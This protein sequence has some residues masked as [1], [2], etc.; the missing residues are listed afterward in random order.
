MQLVGAV[1]NDYKSVRAAEI[2]LGGLTVLFGPNGAG[3]TNLLEAIAW[4]D[5]LARKVLKRPGEMTSSRASRLGLAYRFAVNTVGVGSDAELL[6]EMLASPWA[7]GMRPEKISEGIGAYCGS[8]WWGNGGDLYDPES[9]D[10]LK[11]AYGIIKDRSLVGVDKRIYGLAEKLIDMLFYQ[12]MFIVQE[13][14]AVELTFDRNSDIGKQIVKIANSLTGISGVL[15][16]ALGTLRSWSGRWPPLMLMS[17]GPGLDTGP[18][19][20]A[21]FG[22]FAKQLGGVQV[23][24]GDAAAAESYLEQSLPRVHDRFMHDP[25]VPEGFPEQ[26]SQC[27]MPDHGARSDGKFD[28]DEDVSFGEV[29]QWLEDS[30][31]W[32]RVKPS[33]VSTVSVIERVANQKCPSFIAEQGRIKLGI[34]STTQWGRVATRTEITFKF[35]RTDGDEESAS[36]G[37]PI[38][39]VGASYRYFGPG[40]IS[41]AGLGAGI[42]RWV[43]TVVRLAIDACADGEVEVRGDRDSDEHVLFSAS[44]RPRVLLIDEPEQHLHPYAQQDIAEWAFEQSTKNHAVV[45]A[46][47]S[48]AFFRF[49]PEGVNLCQVSR[50]GSWTNV[51]PLPAVHGSDVIRRARELG[52]V[53]GL[54]EDALAQLTRAVVVVE[55]EW[56]R[57]MLHYF[58]GNEIAERRLL[59]V[60]LQGSNELGALADAAV[61]PALGLPVIALLDEVRANSWEDLARLGG[62]L[63]KTERTLRDLAAALHDRLD[64]VRYE[65]PDVICA[66]PEEAVRSAYPTAKFPGW[67]TMLAEWE[68][69]VEAGDTDLPFKKW[70]LKSMELPSRQRQPTIFFRAVLE[71]SEG[72]LP[73]ERFRDAVAQIL[74]SGPECSVD[75]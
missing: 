19:F 18:G 6:L 43:A 4:H 73:G 32:T 23:V 48:P 62:K 5:P 3:K 47:H 7:T 20:P 71:K 58:Y 1:V 67:V 63:T 66:L 38:G 75:N 21:G 45:V 13:D 52:F 57:V 53:L 51:M 56:D 55:G 8:C 17:R 29:N 27:L 33:L 40:E 14:F 15:G 36:W 12:P 65:D 69:A 2:P 72:T 22:W 42:G 64:I 60:P 28:D 35:N 41:L 61:I 25:H 30:G 44:S 59:V 49:A 26:C 31:E 9:R 34:R 11:T 46:T 68:I 74:V 50:I 16:D 37:G 54:A 10:T 39:V 70:A 24:S